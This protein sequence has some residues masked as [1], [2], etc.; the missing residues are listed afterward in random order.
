MASIDAVA[1]GSRF[2]TA[3][4]APLTEPVTAVAAEE[5]IDGFFGWGA[6]RPRGVFALRDFALRVVLALRLAV[7]RD[8]AARA[9]FRRFAAFAVERRARVFAV[10]FAAVLR[11]VA[12]FATV[13]PLPAVPACRAE[14][15]KRRKAGR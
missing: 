11:R 8:A 5:S 4:T 13:P 3:A 15:A 9:A 2:F 12:F 10:F 7:L 14:A 1:P 6:L